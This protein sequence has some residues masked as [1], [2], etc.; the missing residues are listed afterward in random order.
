MKMVMDD[1]EDHAVERKDKSVKCYFTDSQIREFKEMHFENCVMIQRRAMMV[2]EMKNLMDRD[3][4][5]DVVLEALKKIVEN[6]D[7]GQNGIKL[8]QN[9]NEELMNKVEL[10]YEWNM[11]KCWKV[12]DHDLMMV[13]WYDADG[14]LRMEEKMNPEDLQMRITG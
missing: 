4:D 2:K 1:P 14:Q 9:E 13:G 12:L 11:V 5:G 6:D 7:I 3:F 10:G 8:L